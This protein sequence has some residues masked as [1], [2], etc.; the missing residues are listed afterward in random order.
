MNLTHIE[1][2]YNRLEPPRKRSQTTYPYIETLS[3]TIRFI[4]LFQFCES[5]NRSTIQFVA[6]FSNLTNMMS[7]G[8]GRGHPTIRI[9]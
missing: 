5:L 8:R 9:R 7:T 1:Q 3:R 6:S 2:V 4:S